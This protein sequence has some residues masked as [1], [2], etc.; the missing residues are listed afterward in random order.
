M[1]DLFA[2]LD[3]RSDIDEKIASAIVEKCCQ[4]IKKLQ[5]MPG[6]FRDN[7]MSG[8][9][10]YDIRYSYQ[11]KSICMD[12]MRATRI[13]LG[14]RPKYAI[15]MQRFFEET[16]DKLL[17]EMT[18]HAEKVSMPDINDLSQFPRYAMLLKQV[19]GS[20]K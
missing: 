14:L 1:A 16:L 11:I 12:G 3:A 7:R 18:E 2:V 13:L 17:E 20:A 9:K 5:K 19:K 8:N 6:A 4:K 15:E 10:L